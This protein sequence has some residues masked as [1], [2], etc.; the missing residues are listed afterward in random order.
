MLKSSGIYLLLAI[1]APSIAMADIYIHPDSRSDD[2][3]VIHLSDMPLEGFEVLIA[4]EPPNT[5]PQT[6]PQSLQAHKGTAIL[7]DAVTTAS[8]QTGLQP[9][10]LHA[11]IATESGYDAN[12]ISSRGARGLMQLM[13]STARAL[14]V[15]DPHEPVSNILGGARYL[16]ELLDQFGTVELAL[17][18]YNAGP[19][20]VIKYGNR[21]PPY[22][23]TQQYVR[24]VLGLAG[25]E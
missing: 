7:N 2:S 11:V 22:R 6:P 19:A 5:K 4:S 1:A 13:P 3:S 15:A 21:I 10:L 17:A 12:A 20:T 18:A 14:Q 8:K 25:M 16:R 23:E 9:S 24:K